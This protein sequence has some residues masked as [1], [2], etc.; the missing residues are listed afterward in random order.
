MVI[1]KIDKNL[2]SHY[3]KHMQ[4]LIDIRNKKIKFAQNHMKM[5]DN[6]RVNHYKISKYNENGDKLI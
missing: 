1:I 6:L 2:Q 5:L 3:E 4:R